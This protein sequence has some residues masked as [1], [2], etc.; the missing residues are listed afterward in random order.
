MISEEVLQFFLSEPN[1]PLFSVREIAKNP[2]HPIFKRLHEDLDSISKDVIEKTKE[3]P[4][5]ICY[6]NV[7]NHSGD[8]QAVPPWSRTVFGD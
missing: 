5:F 7:Q 8:H 3:N 1:D 6:L 4:L 2:K